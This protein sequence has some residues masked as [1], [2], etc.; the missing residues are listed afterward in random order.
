V[1]VALATLQKGLEME[2]VYLHHRPWDE[3]DFLSIGNLQW[4]PALIP[5]FVDGNFRDDFSHLVED[6]AQINT[7]RGE[8]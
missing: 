5:F 1:V 6:L 8:P 7:G 4:N 3:L 2:G